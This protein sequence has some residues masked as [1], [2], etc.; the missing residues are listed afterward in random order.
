[1][2]QG[3]WIRL[4]VG[5]VLAGAALAASAGAV[6][7]ASATAAPRLEERLGGATLVVVGRVSRIQSFDYDQVR[8]IH[9]AVDRI[10]KGAERLDGAPG[11]IEIV[12]MRDRASAPDLLVGGD[13][14]VAFL[15]P[16]RRGSYLD[17]TLGVKRRWQ[18][19]QGRFGVVADRDATVVAEA[20]ALIDRIADRSRAPAETAAERAAER[21]AW[22]F[23]AIAARHPAMVEGGAAGL[24]GVPGLAGDLKPEESARLQKAV[25]RGDLPARVH[26]AL[27]DAI[28]EARL[29]RLAPTLAALTSDAPL[30]LDASWR[31][32]SALGVP[33]GPN[34]F[35]HYLRHASA[36]ARAVA[37][38]HFIATH[39]ATAVPRMAAF[40][41]GEEGPDVRIAALEAL[42]PT[43][44]DQATELIEQAF[45]GDGE[46]A[47]R[48]AAGRVLFERG[49]DEAAESFARLAFAAAPEGQRHA[50]ALLMAL[51]RPSGDPTLERI[52]D[53]HP[54][55]K[56]RELAEHG[57]PDS[58]H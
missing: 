32:Q 36:E 58:H 33:P 41:E 9:F 7:A 19:P 12:E 1:V 31:A 29:A 44:G 57:F 49:G 55:P 35:E 23:D 18:P 2:K 25:Q 22:T 6:I 42:G 8:V 47:V 14:A 27:I 51:G 52:R 38:R 13:H 54:D 50:V 28:G 10:V 40:L 26:A 48:Q 46:L 34:A 16:M 45:V 5:L 21:R 43:S 15:S 3:S 53:T 30:V 20:A 39:P 37:A 24:P 56:V 17:A 4:A 11:S